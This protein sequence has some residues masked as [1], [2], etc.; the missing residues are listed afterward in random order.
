MR[1]IGDVLRLNAKYYP[2]KRAVVDSPKELTWRELNERVNRF[3]N[4]LVGLGCRKGDRIAI[5]AYSSIEYLESIFACA[6]A[7]L[8]YVPLNFRLS[9][10][11]LV[12]IL[13]DSTPTTLIFGNEF[14]NIA[15]GFKSHFSLNYIC[16]GEDLDWAKEYESLIQP[17]SSVEPPEEWV[18][19]GDIA[20]IFYTS[21]TT[22]RAKGVVHNHRG[23]LMGAVNC[24][25][26]GELNHDDVYLLNVPAICH[27]AGW[28][29]VLATAYVGG[30]IVIAKLR[31]FDPEVILT[32]IQNHSITNLQM[33]PVTIMQ[34]IEFPEI[35]RYDLSSLRMI[36]YATAP[37]PA[38]PLKK[39]LSIF[40]NIFMQPYGLTETGPNVTCLR[41]KQHS[42]SGLSD[43]Q[44]SKRLKSCGRPCYGVSVR[45]VDEKGEEVPPHTVGEILVKSNDMME[46]YWNNKEETL[47]VVKDGW[48]HTGDLATYD[49]DYY[50][51]LVDRKKDMIISGGL[52][53]YPAEVEKVIYEHP[54]VSECAVVGV[55]D[56]TW[57]EAVK[58]FVVLRPGHEVTERE[59]ID[60]C[61]KSL[62][63]YK[64]PRSV[65]FVNGLPRNPQG[66]ILK[67]V[68]REK[69]WA[70]R[71][72][73]I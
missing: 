18:S 69:Y 45:L 55:P 7:G 27:T 70:D 67:R 2:D 15:S 10:E 1:G 19:E 52:N 5:L 31:G 4:A 51:Y 71:D 38:G 41:R 48:L 29:W 28:V 22:G 59:I 49:E 42:I 43:Q 26:D 65:E 6:K 37:M 54:M 20:E 56:D 44:A 50:I 57:G 12:H 39:A 68:L 66:K 47:K 17:S 30:S 34:L 3:S 40:G 32:T 72:R 9:V 60:S 33:V 63:S 25:I 11:E 35:K 8:I 16:I 62:A 73:K 53:I 23:R 58:A 13:N 24:V 64:K 36:F 14:S 46:G 21:G 61:R